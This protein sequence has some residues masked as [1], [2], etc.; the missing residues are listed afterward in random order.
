MWIAKHHGRY[1]A[2]GS[3]GDELPAAYPALGTCCK[4]P[5][6]VLACT[7][8]LSPAAKIILNPLW[9]GNVA[10]GTKDTNWHTVVFETCCSKTFNTFN[11]SLVKPCLK[12]LRL[13]ARVRRLS[14]HIALGTT[15][16]PKEARAANLNMYNWA[17]GWSKCRAPNVFSAPLV[18][19]LPCVSSPRKES[20]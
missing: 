7:S 13:I 11:L 9:K 17:E 16:S 10:N 2:R 8:A 20:R 14:T 15:P 5:A 6:S 3:P 19:L 1:W 18:R 12:R 4:P